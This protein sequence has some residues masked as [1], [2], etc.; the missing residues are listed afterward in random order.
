MELCDRTAAE[1][2]AMLRKREVSS[3]EI[4]ESVFSRIR[5][6]E[7]S[8]HAYIT[9]TPETALRQAHGPSGLPRP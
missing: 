8:L 2:L 1:L 3:R 5:D 7:E 4:T 6:R 9:I